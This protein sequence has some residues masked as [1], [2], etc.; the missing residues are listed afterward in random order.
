MYTTDHIFPVLII[1]HLVN[2]EGE[3]TTPHKLET[4]TKPSVSNLSALFYPCGVRK[5]TAHVDKNALNMHH[6]SQNVFRGIS[7]GIPQHQK[8]YLVYVPSA[9]KI[10]F[11]C[12]ILFDGKI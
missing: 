7:V 4:G 6:Q 12:D 11:S 9:W 1:K 2:Q 3:Q 5:S 10:V 8:G